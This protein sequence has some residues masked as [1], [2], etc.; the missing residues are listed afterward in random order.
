MRIL[1]NYHSSGPN[2]AAG[3]IAYTWSIV[4]ALALLSGQDI[5]LCASWDAEHLPKALPAEQLSRE[6]TTNF[7]KFP[8]TRA[9]RET[10]Q[11]FEEAMERRGSLGTMRFPAARAEFDNPGS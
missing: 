11:I 4:G 6:S 7:R 2:V 1:V 9:A 10:V 5:F 8:W 3:I